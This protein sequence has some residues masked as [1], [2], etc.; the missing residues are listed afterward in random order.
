MTLVA[1]VQIPTFAIAVARRD[2]PALADQPLILYRSGRRGASVY[3]AS[4]ETGVI[5][6]MSLRQ[7]TVRCPDAV[8]HPADPTR[9]RQAFSALIRLLQSFSPQVATGALLPDA[10]VDLDLGR[11][12]LSQGMV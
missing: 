7:A 1:C 3:A 9:D 10:A 5:P 4:Q 11:S 2:E 8:Y 6:G 12:T